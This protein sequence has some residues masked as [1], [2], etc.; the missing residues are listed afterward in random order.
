MVQRRRQDA[1]FPVLLFVLPAHSQLPGRT[2]I[3]VRLWYPGQLAVG[4]IGVV[5]PLLNRLGQLP[6]SLP[7]LD[8]GQD[9]VSPSKSP[10]DVLVSA[11]AGIE[12]KN[13]AFSLGRYQIQHLF[14]H[15]YQLLKA[16]FQLDL[17]RVQTIDDDLLIQCCP[18]STQLSPTS[19]SL[20]REVTFRDLLPLLAGGHATDIDIQDLPLLPIVVA[21]PLSVGLVGLFA[22]LPHFY[23]VVFLATVQ[24]ST[25][26]RLVR[27]PGS[28]KSSLQSTVWA[29]S[30][31]DLTQALPT[32]QDVDECIPQLLQRRVLDSLLLDVHPILGH[33]PDLPLAHQLCYSDQA[34]TRR[35]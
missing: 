26:L 15:L 13:G 32:G 9:F 11:S 8:F 33:R 17:A 19:P 18:N 24:R 20:T 12:T 34:A 23:Y 29:Y 5:I 7:V 2:S 35:R 21:I 28:S 16:L 3:R 27:T 14:G 6:H 31:V 30:C 1:D 10:V 25:H 4:N 22:H